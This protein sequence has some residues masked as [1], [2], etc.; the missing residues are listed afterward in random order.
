MRQGSAQGGKALPKIFKMIAKQTMLADYDREFSWH[1]YNKSQTKEKALFVNIL[2]KL[3]D[4]VIEPIHNRGRK[5]RPLKDIIFALVMKEYLQTSSRRVQSDLK[6]FAMSGFIESEI[7]F[8]T[9]LDHL[10]KRDLREF[11]LELIEIASLPMRKIE[12]DFAI[13]STGFSTSRYKTFFNM[14]HRGEGRWREYRKCHAVCGVKTNIITSVDITKG[15]CGD[16]TQFEPLA[17]GTARNFNIREF[18]ADKAYLS[19]NN[20]KLIKE[21]GGQAYIPFKK[22]TTGKCANK[23]RSYFKTAFRFFK[24][25]KEGYL[26]SYHKRSN[27]ESTFSMIKRRFGN[28]IKCKKEI[29]QD[30]EILAKVLAHNICV[31]VQEIFLNNINVDFNMHIKNYVAR[32]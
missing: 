24:E 32:N 25:N 15:Y 7:P 26:D 30:N 17:K 6:M 13:D 3:C 8:N 22:N 10:N 28:N 27:I 31:L 21:L 5:P 1:N 2:G 9:L 12:V 20:F 29:S 19:S 18:S 16:S 4:L 11:I 23:N 14:K